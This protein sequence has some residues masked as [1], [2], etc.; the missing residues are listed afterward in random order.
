MKLL[1]SK[2]EIHV[3]LELF[4]NVSVTLE[5]VYISAIYQ[6]KHCIRTVLSVDPDVIVVKIN[7]FIS[8][9]SWLNIYP[10]VGFQ[11]QMV[12]LY[13]ED[14]PCCF[15]W[16]LHHFASRQQRPVLPGSLCPR[17]HLLTFVFLIAAVSPDVRWYLFAFICISLMVMLNI[18]SCAY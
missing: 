3:M 15:P 10:E 1:I 5:Q 14:S 18:T 13:F 8:I 11:D 16:Q 7:R 12:V 17:Q 2:N 6:N 4:C 9:S